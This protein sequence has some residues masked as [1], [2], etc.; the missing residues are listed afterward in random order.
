MSQNFLEENSHNPE[1]TTNESGLQ[2]RVIK[3]GK[4]KSPR[5]TDT[6]KVHYV[7]KLV[8]GNEFDNSYK[9]GKPAQF[10]VNGVIKGWTEALLMMQKG[11]HWEI[12]I[13][14][15]LGYGKKGV[16]GVIP[17]N[18]ILIFELELIQPRK[19]IFGF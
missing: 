9:K 1:I 13:P 11:S 7:G 5:E 19:S 10:K 17:P 8:N 14:P 16:P 12:F 3:K 2:Y 18:A 4:G 15:E 6:I